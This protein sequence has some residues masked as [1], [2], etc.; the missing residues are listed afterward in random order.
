MVAEIQGLELLK[1]EP[2]VLLREPFTG[3]TLAEL[4]GNCLKG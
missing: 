2:A 3:T 1:V 4:V